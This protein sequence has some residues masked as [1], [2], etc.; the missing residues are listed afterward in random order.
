MLQIAILCSRVKSLDST[1]QSKRRAAKERNVSSTKALQGEKGK[2]SGEFG[3]GAIGS[4][5][6]RF[7]KDHSIGILGTS[8]IVIPESDRIDYT[9]APS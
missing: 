8:M 5:T 7:Q 9:A 1:T 2:R 6:F 3:V 4:R